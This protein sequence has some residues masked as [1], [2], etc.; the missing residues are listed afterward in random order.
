MSVWMIIPRDALIFR[1]GRPFGPTPGVRALSLLF[2]YPSTIAGAVRTRAGWDP[3]TGFDKERI[4]ELLTK[5]VRGP[6]LVEMEAATDQIKTWYFPAPGDCQLRKG[7]DNQKTIPTAWIRPVKTPPGVEVGLPD[8]LTL[9][10][11]QP[12]VNEKGYPHAPRFWRWEDLRTWLVDPAAMQ[13][14]A[15]TSLGMPALPMDDRM[16]VSIDAQTGTAA[17][18]RL[19]QTRALSFV[20]VLGKENG[21][22]GDNHDRRTTHFYALVVETDATLTPGPDFLGGERRIVAWR[23]LENEL[24][25]MPQE[26]EES[27]VASGHCRLMLVTPGIFEKGYLPTWLGK[28]VPGAQVTVVAAATGR[29]QAI[30][31]W[32]YKKRQAKPSRRM[33]PAG[34]VYFLRVE[35]D[36]NARRAFAR[37]IWLQATSDDEQD[38]RD[39]FGIALLG[40]WNGA[41][42]TLEVK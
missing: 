3:Q 9:V 42:E 35:G 23:A 37:R 21:Q 2:P 29:P 18:K 22:R 34:A 10:S 31:G 36:E 32:N 24:P 30:S 40:T 4:P 25:A 5:Q 1:D 8:G 17:E 28:A 33:A 14:I 15:P 26:I 7:Q 16:H 11:A 12:A 38:R 20:R 19:F 6:F 13:Q 39:G 41:I 27:L